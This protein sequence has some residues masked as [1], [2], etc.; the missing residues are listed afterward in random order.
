MVNLESEITTHQQGGI[1]AVQLV[2]AAAS[3]RTTGHTAMAVLRDIRLEAIFC[4][5][6][7]F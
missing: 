6:L 4:K 1:T 7:V 5:S 3:Q 2:R